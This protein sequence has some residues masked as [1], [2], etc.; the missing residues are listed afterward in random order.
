[1]KTGLYYDPSNVF[2]WFGCAITVKGSSAEI[3][4]HADIMPVLSMLISYTSPYLPGTASISIHGQHLFW[5]SFW[6][7]TE[8]NPQITLLQQWHLSFQMTI[9][10]LPGCLCG[11]KE[12]QR[13]LS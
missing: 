1:M 8:C 13:D 12:H 11:F 4:S 10:E 2:L 7:V 3:L 9:P 6:R 5:F